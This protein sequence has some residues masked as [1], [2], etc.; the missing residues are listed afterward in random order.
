MSRNFVDHIKFPLKVR[1]TQS[2]V[3][4][5]DTAR[6]QYSSIAY[7][8]LQPHSLEYA[9]F[10]CKTLARALTDVH[11]GNKPGKVLGPRASPDD[12]IYKIELW[13]E[14]DRGVEK[15]LA[16]LANITDAKSFLMIAR[17]DYPGRNIKLRQG[18]R[19]I[20]ENGM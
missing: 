20:W 1:R 13:F 11:D 17:K 9:T 15:T 14:A 6:K 7:E 3:F 10:V 4:I 2:H 12:L 16:A 8:P 19:V 5:E 18:I